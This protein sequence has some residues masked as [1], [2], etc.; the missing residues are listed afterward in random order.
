MNV[1]NIRFWSG[2]TKWGKQTEDKK[3]DF[4]KNKCWQIGWDKEDQ[5]RGATQAWSN[6]QQVKIGD[7][8]AFHGYGG[9]NDLIIYQI[10]QITGIDITN[11]KLYYNIISNDEN[12]YHGKAPKLEKGGWFGTLFQIT[13]KEAIEKIFGKYI[14]NN[15]NN[16]EEQ[17][18]VLE[19]I[20]LLKSTHNLILHGAPGTG[21]TY[22]AN[23]IGKAMGAEIGFVQFHPNYDYTDFI[24]G[25]RPINDK[26]GQIG[27]KRKDGVFKK[28]CEQALYSSAEGLVDNFDQVMESFVTQFEDND[29]QGIDIPLISGKRTFRIALNSNGDG[30]VTLIKQK[31][32]S[33]EK[34]SGRFY[35]FEQC[36]RVYKNLPGV[37]KGGLDNYRKA[38]VAFLRKNYGLKDYNPGTIKNNSNKPFIFII[39][40]INRGEL[41]K[42]FGELFFAIEPSYRGS[43]KCRELRTQYANLQDEANEFDKVLNI[44]NED[45]YGHFFV[46]ENVY[47]IGTMND[48][49]RSVESMDFAMRRRFTFKEISAKDSMEILDKTESWKERN[50]DIVDIP[51]TEIKNRMLNLNNAITSEAIGF[52]EAYQIGAAYFLNYANYTDEEKP[53][54]A[55][56][57]YNLEPLLREY[58][59]GQDS[60]NDKLEVLHNAYLKSN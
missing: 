36:Y 40:E 56:W 53:F 10:S 11:G 52:S 3:E 39:D 30:F 45:D 17:N 55:L 42:I 29:N 31:D 7:Y 13:G 6:I 54:E 47:I 14:S 43:K 24:E 26:N 12:L 20:K 34:D 16:L 60:Y 27:F 44:T 41:S 59:R 57:N 48:I 1:E 50:K 8:L 49:D 46:P 22:L 51:V 37:P 19:L 15:K 9:Q 4:N 35:N 21:K 32:G 38:I 23:Q 5:S 58:L 18:D 28:F 33:Y 2:G 25:L